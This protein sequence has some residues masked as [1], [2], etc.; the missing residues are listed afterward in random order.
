METE[1]F[2]FRV[3]EDNCLSDDNHDQ[4]VQLPS[5]RVNYKSPGIPLPVIKTTLA[6]LLLVGH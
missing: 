2:I 6:P 4:Q 3:E 1:T 5:Q